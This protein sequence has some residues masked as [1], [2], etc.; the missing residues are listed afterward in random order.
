MMNHDNDSTSVPEIKVY[1]KLSGPIEKL[2]LARRSLLFAEVS[3]FTYF[4]EPV[5]VE[6]AGRLGLSE[7]R[8]FDRGGAQA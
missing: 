5:A 3:N 4:H 8:F 2:S 1:S 6:L 7:S